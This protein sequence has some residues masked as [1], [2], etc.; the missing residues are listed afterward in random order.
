M[1]ICWICE[2]NFLETKFLISHLDI[3]HDLNS[4]TEFKCKKPNC[5]R[6]LSNLNAFKKH[7]KSHSNVFSSQVASSASNIS[8][9][10]LFEIYQYVSYIVTY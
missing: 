4:I 1:S 6:T 2:S 5:Y 3:F 8:A 10:N 7:L 9:S